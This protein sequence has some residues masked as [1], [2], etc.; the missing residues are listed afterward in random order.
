MH[1]SNVLRSDDLGQIGIGTHREAHKLC[2]TDSSRHG[3]S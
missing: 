3:H 2:D 1:E